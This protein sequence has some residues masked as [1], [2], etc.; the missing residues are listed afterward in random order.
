MSRFSL[1][2]ISIMIVALVVNKANGFYSTCQNKGKSKGSMAMALRDVRSTY[3]NLL[4]RQNSLVYTP[5]DVFQVFDSVFEDFMDQNR[6]SIPTTKNG[7][8]RENPFMLNVD[9]IENPKQF[10]LIVDL[11]GFKKDD[12]TITL[13]DDNVMNISARRD[14]K[15]EDNFDQTP[16]ED[17]D[18]N[19][20]KTQQETAEHTEY[21][22]STNPTKYHRQ[23][24]FTG[25]VS[26]SFIVPD[27]VDMEN[28]SSTHENGLL[29]ISLPR[30]SV[31]PKEEQ[32]K[33]KIAIRSK[34]EGN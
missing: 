5:F 23:E 22:L 17:T 33:R 21:V 30:K 8:S 1:F 25:F 20:S 13:D 4:P 12:I 32:K 11:P 16:D 19:G 14:E 29:T 18:K 31:Q 2:L 15:Y 27:D 34:D 9:I 26:R 7:V 10:E 6:L 28:V 3:P 24:R